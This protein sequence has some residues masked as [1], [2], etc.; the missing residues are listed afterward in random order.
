MH[1]VLAPTTPWPTGA[2]LHNPDPQPTA[3]QS[4]RWPYLLLI[5]GHPWL[6]APH[7]VLK[8]VERVQLPV[9]PALD[10]VLLAQLLQG[11]GS[12]A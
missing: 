5:L 4:L 2:L 10:V 11:C 1:A 9:R 3:P 7:A 6:P 12:D 8:V